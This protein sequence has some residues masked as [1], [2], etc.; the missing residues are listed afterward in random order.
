MKP[1]F[2]VVVAVCA[3]AALIL[4]S[5]AQM[6]AQ[7]KK[8]AATPAQY[9]GVI[10]NLDKNAKTFML[11]STTM[12]AGI[13]VKYTDKTKFTFRNKPSSIDELKEGRRVMVL[14]DPAQKKEMIALRVDFR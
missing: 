5:A 9:S 11:H 12:T 10:K 6:L 4:V 1:R 3:C 7:E 2:A 8:S 14:I 13:Q